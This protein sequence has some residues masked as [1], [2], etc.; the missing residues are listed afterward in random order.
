MVAIGF[1]FFFLALSFLLS[2]NLISPLRTGTCD[3][4]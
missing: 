2:K 3:R 4:S 1:A